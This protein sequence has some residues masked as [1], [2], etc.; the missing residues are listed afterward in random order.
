M[1]QIE[2]S[3]Y[4]GVIDSLWMAHIDSMTHLREGVALRGYGQRDPLIEYKEEAYRMFTQMLESIRHNTVDVIFKLNLKQQLP[5]EML[6]M[7]GPEVIITNED[8]IE[9]VLSGSRSGNI[10]IQNGG[11]G[12]QDLQSNTD[13]GNPVVIKTDGSSVQN[14][15]GTPET[16]RNDACPC[17]SGKKYKKCHGV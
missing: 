9:E 14:I 5:P 6:Q 10:R 8:Q 2:R 12:R 3:M 7:R 15:P 1:R 17:G 4:L 16:G 11:A 13:S